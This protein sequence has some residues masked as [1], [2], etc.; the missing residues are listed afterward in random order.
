MLRLIF[1]Q[2][3]GRSM[4]FSLIIAH[5]QIEKISGKIVINYRDFNYVRC[6]EKFHLTY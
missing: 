6:N 2:V 5:T 4:I 3:L 1:I